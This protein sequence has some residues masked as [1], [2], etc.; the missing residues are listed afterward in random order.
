MR[1]RRGSHAADRETI[2]LVHVGHGDGI[3]DDARQR[4]GVDQLLD[5]AVGQRL[6]EQGATGE[7]TRRDPHIGAE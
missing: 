1:Q 5:A 2:T 3:A 7:D 6:F 4:G